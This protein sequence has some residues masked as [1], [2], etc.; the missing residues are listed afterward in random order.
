MARIDP[1]LDTAPRDG[2]RYLLAVA[3]VV[4]ALYVG[5]E[6]FVPIAL[7]ILLSFVLA[8]GVRLLH[9]CHLG[10]VVPVL[11]MTSLAFLVILGLGGVLVTQLRGLADD[12]PRYESTI[13]D[14]VESLRAI[15]SGGSMARFSDF[16]ADLG[17]HLRGSRD[18]AP[19]RPDAAVQEGPTKQGAAERGTSATT[20]AVSAGTSA[21]SA[22][23]PTRP[24]PVVIEHPE[25]LP[26][27]MIGRYLTPVLHPLLT[28]GLVAIYVVFMLMQRE[29]LRNRAIRLFGA[30]DLHR[31]TAALDD[32]A[33][34]LSRYLVSQISVNTGAGLVMG[35][36][37][38]WVGVPSPILFGI[39]F[40]CLRFVPYVGAP[41]A[42]A[43]PLA[44][45]A[46]VS[47]GWSTVLWTAGLYVVVETT[48]GQAVEPLL[49]GRNTGLSPVAVVIAAT[50]WTVLWGPVGLVLATPMTVCLVVLGRH[51]EPL[52]FLDVMLG[53]RAPLSPPEVF[54][55]RMLAEDPTETSD[56]AEQL[57]K[58]MTLP[59]YY[60]QVLVPGLL[61]AQEDVSQGRLDLDRQGRIGAAAAE[62]IE[63]LSDQDGEAA[64]ES[65]ASGLQER[66]GRV[67]ADPDAEPAA[68]PQEAPAPVS[69]PAP[70]PL[71]VPDAW[72]R[73]G[74]VLCVGGR[75]PLDDAAAAAL[76]QVM[77]KHGFGAIA[78]G[79]EMLSKARIAELPVDDARLICLSC[80][81]GSS[82]A[83][84]RFILRRLRRR[85]GR[86][87]ILCGAWWRQ[88]GQGGADTAGPD[89]LAGQDSVPTLAEAVA[90]ALRL[91]SPQDAE[92]VAP[93]A[94]AP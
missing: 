64:P 33:R 65:G 43:A 68:E 74:A 16:A 25:V 90:H 72:D 24:V 82:A 88:A 48:L 56:Q 66:L 20:P 61:L 83:Y 84:L 26:V 67:G 34:R 4:T 62:V 54:Y 15:M 40:G 27:E 58:H 70:S 51:V 75:G 77:G 30:G 31:S 89:A 78:V 19:G 60:D 10:R 23:T 21:V 11:L 92:A 91:A 7:A 41:L 32:A 22:G 5:A 1:S 80:L 3:I 71:P 44:L 79:Y 12:L 18:G 87:P 35:L 73:P 49:Y 28:A 17:R 45:A 2:L 14:K 63:N 37:L 46:A 85:S 50:F 93:G 9:R 94:A 38:A 81:D 36:A 57:L 39:I 8:P 53:D 59:D 69:L 47:P 29:D 86:V 52:A 76:A 55:Q 42:A 13:L 6:I